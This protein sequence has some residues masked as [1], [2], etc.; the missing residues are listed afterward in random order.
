[1][2]R[3]RRNVPVLVGNL[4]IVLSL[5]WIGPSELGL[6]WLILLGLVSIL[7]YNSCLFFGRRVFESR[8]RKEDQA[9]SVSATKAL[10]IVLVVVGLVIL[11][12]GG[13]LPNRLP[14]DE[15]NMGS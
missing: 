14:R 1:M 5:A 8:A 6:G 15:R 7:L 3:L 2:S 11:V 12:I 9:S 13:V 4:D 10:P